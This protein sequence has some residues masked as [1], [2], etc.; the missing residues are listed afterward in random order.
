MLWTGEATKSFT[1]HSY[2][3]MLTFKKNGLTIKK[4]KKKNNKKNEN[5]NIQK[6]KKIKKNPQ[7]KSLWE[8]IA[9]IKDTKKMYAIKNVSLFTTNLLEIVKS[10]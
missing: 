1:L 8:I 5:P 6:P 4:I 2:K 9:I 10:Y 3:Q 7:K